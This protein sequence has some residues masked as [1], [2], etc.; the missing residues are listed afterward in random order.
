GPLGSMGS[1]LSSGQP[2]EEQLKMAL[3]KAQQLVNSN[4]LVV[5]S[6]TYAGYCSRVKKLFDQLG[7][8]Y[9]TIE[10]DQESDG[11]AI[12]AA[13]LQWTGQRTVPNVF[14]GGKHIGGCD[15][16]MEKHR[17]GKLV[18]MLTECGAIAIESTA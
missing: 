8:R 2:T 15:S 17:D 5:F 3:Q 7:A 12:Q 14:I 1:V 18:P 16:V 4:P 10:L 11:D 6:K 13:L 9:Q